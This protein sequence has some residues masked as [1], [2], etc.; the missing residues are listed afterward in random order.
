MG[1][2]SPRLRRA[3]LYR[4]CA[5]KSQPPRGG[6]RRPHPQVSLACDPGS[7]GRHLQPAVARS[8]PLTVTGLGEF[9]RLGCPADRV[10]DIAG[11]IVPASNIDLL[12]Q[13][14]EVPRRLDQLTPSIPGIAHVATSGDR[15]GQGH[16]APPSVQGF[17]LLQQ[18]GLLHVIWGRDAGQEGPGNASPV[19]WAAGEPPQAL[20]KYRNLEPMSPN[21]PILSGDLQDVEAT[22]LLLSGVDEET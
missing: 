14:A 13:F 1:K 12:F 19:R 20:T 4:R 3:W 15:A 7:G 9:E 18:A 2:I 17:P 22:V 10:A 11:V 5:P 6:R 21:T 16:L 8:T